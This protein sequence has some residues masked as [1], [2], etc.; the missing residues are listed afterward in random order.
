MGRSISWACPYTSKWIK[1]WRM[2]RTHFRVDIVSVLNLCFLTSV[3]KRKLDERNY[4]DLQVWLVLYNMS[5]LRAKLMC[6]Y[7]FF[8]TPQK[9]VFVTGWDLTPRAG[10]SP[11]P[12][13]S[14]H[15]SPLVL[16]CTCTRPPIYLPG[17]RLFIFQDP[18]F[19]KSLRRLPCP[20]HS[21]ND[22]IVR[23]IPTAS[24]TIPAP[25]RA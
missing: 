17:H 9:V 22:H 5:S 14:Q 15:S 10:Q 13:R 18:L 2:A 20:P 7:L 24:C 8:W 6:N 21:R 16:A 23:R 4:F 12:R 3:S 19:P 25:S 11:R 1:Q